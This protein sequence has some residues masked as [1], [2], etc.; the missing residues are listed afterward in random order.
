MSTLSYQPHATTSHQTSLGAICRPTKCS[1]RLELQQKNAE[2]QQLRAQ[3]AERDGQIKELQEQLEHT[4]GVLRHREAMLFGSTSKPK[5]STPQDSKDQP[6]DFTDLGDDA[7]SSQHQKKRK[8]GGQK[9]H[10]GHGRKIPEHLPVLEQIH[11]VPPE[12]AVCPKCGRPFSSSGLCEESTEITMEIQLKVIRHKRKRMFRTCDCPHVPTSVTAPPPVKAIPKCL[13]SH[14]FLAYMLSWKYGFQIPLTRIALMLAMEGLS[15]NV[16][17]L[18]GIFQRLTE[19]LLP[20]Y[21]LFQQELRSEERLHVDE[22]S[23]RHFGSSASM[24][25]TEVETTPRKLSW[26]WVFSGNNVT[27]FV[28]DPSRSSTVPQRTLGSDLTVTLITDNFS[29]YRKYLKSAIHVKHAL[30]WAHF[31]RHFED[32]TVSF[33]QLAPWSA[34]WIGRIAELY[35][36]NDQRLGAVSDQIL[37]AQAQ[38]TLEEKIQY[39]H[40]TMEQECKNPQ[41]HEKQFKILTSGMANWPKYTVF[42]QDHRIPMDNNQAERALRPGTLGRK[43]WYGVHADW[44]ATLA[45][46]MMTFIQ[47]ASKHKL[48]STAYLRYVLDRF[49]VHAGK[50][51][52]L[53]E[54]LPWNISKEE[55]E[56]YQMYTGGGPP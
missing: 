43:N 26:L 8:R 48:N 28:V 6:T 5:I 22:T 24:A 2:L 37:F 12:L 44:S 30:C 11:D 45:A 40:T 55:Q 3:L 38:A 29:A 13:Y 34:Q 49:A 35:H 54:L 50:P 20:L 32:A 9:G 27:F 41:L 19:M 1:Y 15:V 39:F 53:Q 18:S 31:R 17:T 23:F 14:A 56:Q 36:L 10:K 16:G 42:V 52:K 21:L 25:F 33:P 51:C 46:M 4:K 47:T 7:F